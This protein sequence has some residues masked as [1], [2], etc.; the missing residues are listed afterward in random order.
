MT[1]GEQQTVN[2]D[3]TNRLMKKFKAK[4]P[5][6]TEESTERTWHNRF[7]HIG[8][9]TVNRAIAPRLF[10]GGPRNKSKRRHK[11]IGCVRGKSTQLPHARSTA[12]ADDFLKLLHI[13]TWGTSPVSAVDKSIYMVVIVDDYSS[14]VFVN[15]VSR[16]YEGA[17][18]ITQE[19]RRS[20]S[21]HGKSVGAIRCDRG[22]EF[23]NDELASFCRTYGIILQETA[24][25]QSQS[26]DR[27]ERQHR[28]LIERAVAPI[29]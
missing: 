11:C 27:V 9:D 29:Q 4:A 7:C 5:T 24:T 18:W 16:K 10:E 21:E 2:V 25:A 8:H 3:K 15:A 1:P 23:D 22:S 6:A 28:T 20:S 14:M 19:I 12:R 26:S 17:S 13:D